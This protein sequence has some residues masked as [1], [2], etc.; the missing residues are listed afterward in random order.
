MGRRSITGGVV[1]KGSNRI[2]YDFRLNGVRYRP[3]LRA[4][5]SSESDMQTPH[6][7]ARGEFSHFVLLDSSLA[8]I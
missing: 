6:Q 7:A 3:T 4:T 2:Q 8:L 5:Y 1:G